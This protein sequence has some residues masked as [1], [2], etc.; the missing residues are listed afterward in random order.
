MDQ[1]NERRVKMRKSNRLVVVSSL[2]S[3]M[4]LA[5][6]AWAVDFELTA[7]YFGKYIWRGQNLDNEPVFQPA[8]SAAL[9]PLSASIWGSLELTNKNNHEHEF[10][11]VDYTLDYTNAFP[12]FEG[13]SYSIGTIY[14]DFPNTTVKYTTELY[15]GLSL[16]WPVS[17]SVIVYHDIDEAE[18][19]Y[20]STGL[21][22]SIE[23]IME[24]S[25]DIPVGLEIGAGL[26]WGSKSYNKYYWGLDG[27]KANDLSL[28][29]SLPIEIDGWNLIPSVNFVTLLSGDI[30]KTDTYSTDS[31]YLFFGI[32]LSKSF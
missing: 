1:S 3:Y 4:M 25:K 24:L 30:R 7:D 13:L 31:D 6:T 19:A 21:S 9:G 22:Y 27:S 12:G 10:T 28:L 29:L 15:W 11:E 8:L 5:G 14:Y 18:G 17:P 26:G 2:I 23:K 20:V 16:D 32:G